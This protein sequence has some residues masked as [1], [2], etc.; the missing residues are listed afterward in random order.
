[1][2]T[3][4]ADPYRCQTIEWLWRTE[5]IQPSADI[6]TRDREDVAASL[7]VL[8]G[9]PGEPFNPTPVPTLR[10]AWTNQTTDQGVIVDSP[11][12]PGTVRSIVVRSGATK[13]GKWLKERRNLVRDFEQAFGH[14]PKDSIHR[15]A[16]FTDNDQT[17]EPA[18]AYYAWA[19][20]LCD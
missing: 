5:K 10:Y 20:L 18:E 9:D 17:R 16:L 3:V 15:V 13:Q 6:R 4:L 8:F 1:M 7:F 2:R 12:L 19:R 14:P 11:Y